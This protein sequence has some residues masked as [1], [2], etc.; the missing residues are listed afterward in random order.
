MCCNQISNRY[1][2]LEMGSDGSP[3]SACLIVFQLLYPVWFRLPDFAVRRGELVSRG[4]KIGKKALARLL[5]NPAAPTAN[6]L[7]PN[8]Q[9]KGVDLRIGLDIAR[10]AL[11]RT[12]QLVVAV[13]GDSD[14][15]PAFKFTRREGM[16]VYLDHLSGPVRREL[17]VHV[18]RVI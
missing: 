9:Q 17:K 5:R 16:R 7:Q 1:D 2:M 6:D 13:T 10:L 14:L 11:C 15:I 18:D 8:I 12:A 3:Y 4:W